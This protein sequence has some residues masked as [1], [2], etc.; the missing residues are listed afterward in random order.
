MCCKPYSSEGSLFPKNNLCF[1]F[2]EGDGVKGG[3][4]LGKW[5]YFQQYTH[6]TI[7][8][9]CE[10]LDLAGKNFEKNGKKKKKKSRFVFRF[11]LFV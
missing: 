8:H 4:G 1:S 5:I 3:L 9:L 2:V 11:V 6:L 7:E 10:P